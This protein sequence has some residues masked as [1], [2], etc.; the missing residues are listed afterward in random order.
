YYLEGWDK[1]WN[2]VGNI[3][4]ANYSRLQEGTYIFKVKAKSEDGNWGPESTL[5][6]I[7][8]LPP[9]YRT[10]WAYTSYVLILALGIYLYL[11]YSRRQERL[12]YEIKLAHLENEKDK[13]L[14]E[15]KL[16]F[17]TNISHEFRSPLSLIINPLKDFLAK[18]SENK[19]GNDLNIAYRNA[20][21]L[22]SLVDHLL[23]FRKADSGADILKVSRFDI[24]HLC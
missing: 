5:L 20:R 6:R 4:T 14:N 21:R 11:L 8:V 1:T 2:Y 17:F 3:R 18:K 15:K 9:W 22:L 13:E 10:W 24:I 19:T 12:K 16:S 7:T 23:L